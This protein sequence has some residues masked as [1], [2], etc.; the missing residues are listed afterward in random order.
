MA[1]QQ[2]FDHY[3][4]PLKGFP[5]GMR[6]RKDDKAFSST[7][8]IRPR[9]KTLYDDHVKIKADLEE[10]RTA[11]GR[12]AMTGK[13]PKI[14]IEKQA[15]L[16]RALQA[17]ADATAAL[18]QR[19][20]EVSKREKI[21]AAEHIATGRMKIFERET[22]PRIKALM[23]KELQR[24]QDAALFRLKNPGTGLPPELEEYKAPP[25]VGHG[26]SSKQLAA[27]ISRL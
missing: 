1:N 20:R 26:D 16:E 27:L 6:L 7:V 9:L 18:E 10:A 8:E 19:L 12:A 5:R 14:E 3:G 25:Q 17:N 22:I 11:A 21:E 23:K 2:A 24:Q 15:Y 4:N 13:D